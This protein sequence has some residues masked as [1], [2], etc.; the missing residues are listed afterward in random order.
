MIVC[1]AKDV[2]GKVLQ[3]DNLAAVTKKV[4]VSP[5]EGWTGWVMRLFELGR[6]G[7]TPRHQHP[8]PH[9]NYVVGGEGILYLDGID[10]EI[11]EGSFAFIPPEATH[12]FRNSGDGKLALICIV[13]EEGDV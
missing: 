13:P 4:L 6:N 8:W 9:I 7:Y 2:A 10:Y 1:Q 5:K 12:Q 3:G 11:T